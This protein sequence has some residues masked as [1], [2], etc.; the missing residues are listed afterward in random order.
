MDKDKS[1][2]FFSIEKKI[3][4][5]ILLC[6]IFSVFN[7]IGASYINTQ[8][9]MKADVDARLLNMVSIAVLQVD[10]ERHATLLTLEDQNSENYKEIKKTLQNIRNSS[11]DIAYIY[12]LR[13]T[14]DNKIAFV[15]DAEES[16][17]DISNLGDIYDDA[18]PNLIN[19]FNTIDKPMVEKEFTTDKWGTWLSGYAPFYDQYGKRQGLLGIDIKASDIIAKQKDLLQV[20]L[21]LLLISVIVSI[22]LGLYISGKIIKS[23][24]SITSVL[25][26]HD[27]EIKLPITNDEVGA[28]A[29]V[30]KE[31][32]NQL[33]VY[34][35]N[36]EDKASEK[37]HALEK[38]NQ[39]MI[40]RELEM[41]KLKKENSQLKSKLDIQ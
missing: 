6:V 31:K 15:V 26:N 32:M 28:L 29:G 4:L 16:E 30:L 5:S 35:K 10:V 23:I 11:T 1:K 38:M 12:T 9:I 7:V 39:L 24:A 22:I 20:Y 3:T 25:I 33:K 27:E 34:S 36:N 37:T 13:E 21:I 19:N 2:K 14:A 18:D 8:K 17:V 40:G 41:I